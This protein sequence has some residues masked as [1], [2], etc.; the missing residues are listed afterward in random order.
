M[1]Q[2]T[3]LAEFSRLY[4]QSRTFASDT[5]GDRASARPQTVENSFAVQVS[6]GMLKGDRE[7]SLE[8]DLTQLIGAIGRRSL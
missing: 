1:S 2:R 8:N 6:R 3:S 4:I 7:F 5:S